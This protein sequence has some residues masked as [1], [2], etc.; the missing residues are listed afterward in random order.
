MPATRAVRGACGAKFPISIDYCGFG[1]RGNLFLSC[2]IEKNRALYSIGDLVRVGFGSEAAENNLFVDGVTTV[3]NFQTK[4]RLY[5]EYGTRRSSGGMSRDG[6][7]ASQPVTS[8]DRTIAS[9]K[10]RENEPN[11]ASGEVAVG[12]WLQWN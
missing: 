9:V 11:F 2:R 8:G 10:N 5:R 4:P 6:A 12:T 1:S 3:E 7:N